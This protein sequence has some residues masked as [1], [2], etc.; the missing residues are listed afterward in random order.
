MGGAEKRRNWLWGGVA[1][2]VLALGIGF[3]LWGAA[4]FP[5]WLDEAYSAYAAAQGLDF[6][7][8]VVPRYETHP[9][10]YYTLVWAWS[11][12][13]GDGLASLRA[14][15]LTASIATAPLVALAARDL[16]RIGG[17]RRWPV[18]LAAL[19]GFA[20]HP[21][22][23][24]MARQVRPYAPM[25]LAY[26]GAIAALIHIARVA[27][28]GRPVP[29][30]AYGLY[31]VALLLVLWLH[32]LGPLFAAALGLGALAI[33]IRP[34]MRAR[35][36]G[37]LI[38]GHAIVGLL[39]LPALLILL[40]QAPTWVRDTWLKFAWAPALDRAP[41][42]FVGPDPFA[43]AAAAL[44]AV[45][46]GVALW[47][48]GSGRRV[49]ALLLSVG[50]LPVIAALLVSAWLAPIFLLRTLT[51]V[52]VPALLLIAAGAGGTRARA[53]WWEGCG[54]IALVAIVLISMGV[55][56]VANR[57]RGP[58]ENW[59]PVVR[60]LAARYRPGD[61]ILAYP[62]EGAL[63]FD[64]AVR[65]LGL[66]M[67]SRAIPTAIPTLSPPLGS[68][69]VSGSRGVPSLDHAH[70]EAIARE[71]AIARAPTI[72][73][74]RVGPWAYDKGDIFLTALERG[75]RSAGTA[76]SGTIDLRGMRLPGVPDS[77]KPLPIPEK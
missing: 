33:L 53:H 72:W 42:L 17:F 19:G 46:G 52:A 74:L 18:L 71:P 39:W 56:D 68:W 35:N 34:G 29:R 12:S 45:L 60:W 3:R 11:Q 64:R 6:L 28:Q 31:L 70:L 59:Y 38:G 67:P 51:P 32:N 77:M 15:G 54:R 55:G 41:M 8:T 43:M 37:W 57:Q 22:L 5:M 20:L 13:F 21:F 63:P 48:T 50:L 73:L 47:R 27:G 69:Y 76:R 4:S 9:P 62:N 30:R 40:D 49:L 14:I 58:Q 44:L 16:A 23:I 1:L 25:T 10:F 2:V 75:R 61:V 7:W 24:E 65:D 36:W 26:A 66:T